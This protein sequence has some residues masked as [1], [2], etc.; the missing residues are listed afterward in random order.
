MG[1]AVSGR[2]RRLQ[3]F[4]PGWPAHHSM[5]AA[6]DVFA[7]SASNQPRLPLQLWEQRRAVR[8]DLVKPAPDCHLASRPPLPLPPCG[9]LSAQ[10]ALAE[11]PR[12]SAA[13]TQALPPYPPDCCPG[14]PAAHAA[15]CAQQ[16]GHRRHMRSQ[17]AQPPHVQ[18][19]CR[20]TNEHHLGDREVAL[21]HAEGL[22]HLGPERLHIR[23]GWRRV[24]QFRPE[25]AEPGHR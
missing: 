12:L 23:P 5:D 2:S 10:R 16:P 18:L 9:M 15:A 25:L 6:L 24:Q 14:C 22:G 20:L 21:V 17:L 4:T 7:D 1:T 11:A 19:G 13:Q 8:V 3:A